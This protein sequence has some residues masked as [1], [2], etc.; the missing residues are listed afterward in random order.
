M[1]FEQIIR[2]VETV[3]ASSLESFQLK[4]NGTMLKMAKAD[5]SDL[6]A[7]EKSTCK[8][9]TTVSAA[10]EVIR[11]PETGTSL[12]TVES[13]LVGIF[14]AAPA[15][16]AKPFVQVGDRVKKG[17]VLAII[18]AMKL[19]NEIESGYDGVVK[20]I[21]AENAKPVEFGQPLFRIEQE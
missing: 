15:E 7:I 2:L 14:Y 16:D 19:M 8:E 6:R 18:E 20:E 12:L 17:Q 13:P 9:E 1:E 5:L 4:Q 3:S 11:Q 21:C 10:A